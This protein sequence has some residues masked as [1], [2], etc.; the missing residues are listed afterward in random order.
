M[1]VRYVSE[2]EAVVDCMG[3][4]WLSAHHRK[5]LTYR[6]FCLIILES[7][8]LIQLHKMKSV[9]I[10]LIEIVFHQVPFNEYKSFQLIKQA[11][12]MW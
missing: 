6:K 9:H 10:A 4:G 1:A 12:K 7:F 3:I 2:L 8:P 5:L 11:G